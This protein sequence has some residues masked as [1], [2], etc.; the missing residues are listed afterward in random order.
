M[1]LQLLP[2]QGKSD[3]RGD[4]EQLSRRRRRAAWVYPRPQGWFEEM[5]EEMYENHVILVEK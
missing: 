2:L 4:G 5:Y 1:R 3:S